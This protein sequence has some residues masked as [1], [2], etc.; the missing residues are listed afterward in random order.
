M[1]AQIKYV[2]LSADNEE[3]CKTFASLMLDY[4]AEL[5]EHDSDPMPEQF[6]HKWINSIIAMQGPSDRHLELCYVD[7]ETLGFLYGKVDHENHNGFIK[8][9]YGYIMEF[10]VRP[11]YRRKGYGKAMF[12]RLKNLF[13]IDGARRMYLTADP[14]TGKPFWEAMGFMNTHEQSPENQLDIYEKEIS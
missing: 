5:N 11:E 2:Q 6:Q 12:C 13:Q 9:G 1:K 4:I 8:P 10:Y 3:L 7:G 14:L